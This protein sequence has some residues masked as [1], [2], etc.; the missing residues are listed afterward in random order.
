MRST[1][2]LLFVSVLLVPRAHASPV[3]QLAQLSANQMSFEGLDLSDD[4]DKKKSSKKKKKKKH[5]KNDKNE[6]TEKTEESSGSSTPA[7]VPDLG[8]T[9][10]SP[11]PTSSSPTSSN[12]SSSSTTTKSGSN[13]LVPD[14]TSKPDNS[15]NTAVKPDEKPAAKA[16]PMSFE[17]IDVTGKSAERQ[18]IDAALGQF[19]QQQYEDA[20]MALEDILRDP[21]NAELQPEAKYLLGKT[22]YRM[23]LY[24]SSL[25]SFRDVLAGGPSSKFFKSSLEWL[26]F[27]AHKT[28]NEEIILD[29]V[30]KYSNYEFPPKFQSEFRYLLAKY[31]FE[32]GRA[33]IDAG[34]DPEGKKELED[35][36][37]LVLAFNKSDPFYGK[38]QYLMGLIDFDTAKQQPALDAFKEVV[39]ANNPRDGGNWDEH[40]RELAFMQLARTHYGAKQNRYAIYYF[41]RIPPGSDQWLESLFE[42]SW[43]H[44]RIGQYEKALGNMITLQAPFFRDEYFPEA[45]ILKA[46]IYYENCRYTEARAILNDFD[47]LYH[48]VRDELDKILKE[49]DAKNSDAQHYFDILEDIEKKDLASADASAGSVVLSRVFKLALTDRDLKATNDSVLEVEHE[50]DLIGTKKDVFKLSDLA[51]NLL[52]TL[53]KERQAL[54]NKGGLIAK[55]KLQKELDYLTELLSQGL[56]IQFETTTKEKDIL[57]AQLEGTNANKATLNPYKDTR[58]VA[59]EEEYWPFEGEYWRDEL[60][61]YEYTLTKGCKNIGGAASAAAAGDGSGSP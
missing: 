49:G 3:R 6:K 39:R 58:S 17:A 38:A 19:K 51:K 32:R 24:H 16:A 28:V 5:N 2:V 59:D 21:K 61:T 15:V 20:A 55:A 56:R 50:M 22:L 41:D 40:L 10:S 11:T 48:P 47:R 60:G 53:K 9:N 18:K 43:A 44:F 27:I 29:E 45:L 1:L 36:T 33:L 13:S 42:A 46:V 37:K 8:G 57:Q 23:G 25:S 31:H 4:D 34:R 12:P 54:I 30:A 52:D 35:G 14:L 26:F 7:A